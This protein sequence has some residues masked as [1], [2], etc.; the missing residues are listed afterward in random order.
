MHDADM[1][2]LWAVSKSGQS[3]HQR[4]AQSTTS[5]LAF[6]DFRR[7]LCTF[8]RSRCVS[9]PKSVCRTISPACTNH[10]RAVPEG[11]EIWPAFPRAATENGQRKDC[12]KA[13]IRYYRAETERFQSITSCRG[14]TPQEE[15][16][17][18]RACSLRFFAVL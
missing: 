3:T 15:R 7:Q 18:A 8:C 6:P 9:P 5:N 4:K 14:R 11:T 2:F 16:D 1:N 12:S 13:R 10:T 17:R